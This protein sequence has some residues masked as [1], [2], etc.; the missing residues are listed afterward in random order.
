MA[1]NRRAISSVRSAGRA[2]LL[3]AALFAIPFIVAHALASARGD[4]G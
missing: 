3:V 1:T 2:L 4:H